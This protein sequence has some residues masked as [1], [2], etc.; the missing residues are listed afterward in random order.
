MGGPRDIWAVQ[1]KGGQSG[2]WHYEPRAWH[3]D[4]RTLLALELPFTGDLSD[5]TGTRD[6]VWIAGDSD[7]VGVI[8]GRAR[9][10]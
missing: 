5:V 8:F 6:R 4:G 1:P 7:G 2:R 9:A 3:F 10:R